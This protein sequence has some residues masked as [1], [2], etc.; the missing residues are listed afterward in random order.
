MPVQN[1]RRGQ[2]ERAGAQGEDPAPAR[3]QGI[4]ALPRRRAL[5]RNWERV[6]REAGRPA[7]PGSARL[8]L[9]RDRIAAAEP[10]PA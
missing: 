4:V 1:P 6:L 5:A 7:G 10:G 8:L 3:A 2:H 9:C